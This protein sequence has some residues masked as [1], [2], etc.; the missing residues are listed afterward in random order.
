MPL[1]ER[2]KTQSSVEFLK[3]MKGLHEFLMHGSDELFE[4]MLN[5]LKCSQSLLIAPGAFNWNS[6]IPI[7][8]LK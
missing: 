8:V 2:C 5:F 7:Q 1:S 4:R 6:K 3:G